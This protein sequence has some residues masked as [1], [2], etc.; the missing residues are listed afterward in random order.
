MLTDIPQPLSPEPPPL[1]EK[2]QASQTSEWYATAYEAES[3]WTWITIRRM[4]EAC[5]KATKTSRKVRENKAWARPSAAKWRRS[6]AKSGKN[7]N[8]RRCSVL[9]VWSRVGSPP[10]RQHNPITVRE[11]LP[12]RGL[13]L[14]D[15]LPGLTGLQQRFPGLPGPTDPHASDRTPTLT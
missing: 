1:T 3:K 15:Q 7:R 5:C 12:L 14:K 11:G 8:P 6:W 4:R 13:L 10:N 9:V 2:P